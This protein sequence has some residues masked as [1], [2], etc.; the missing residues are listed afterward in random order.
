MP[1]MRPE[2]VSNAIRL[3]YEFAAAMRSLIPKDS[4]VDSLLPAVVLELPPDEHGASSLCAQD[5]LFS[6]SDEL[7]LSA[8]VRVGSSAVVPLVHCETV[9]VS[10][11][12]QPP[13]R[14][15]WIA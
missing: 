10:I 13:D 5:N 7:S 1:A 15:H 8:S 11:L 6:W 9:K 2:A 4:A 3:A 14:L 12:G